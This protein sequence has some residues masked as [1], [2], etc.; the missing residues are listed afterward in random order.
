MKRLSCLLLDAN[1]VIHLFKLKIW[2]RLVDQC[3]VHL[4]RTVMGES[5]FYEDDRGQRV[6]F[7]LGTYEQAGTITVFEVSLT[8]IRVFRDRF[9]P[10][11]L[12]LPGPCRS[13]SPKRS[14]T[15]GRPRVWRRAFTELALGHPGRP[16]AAVYHSTVGPVLRHVRRSL[17]YSVD[18]EPAEPRVSSAREA[19]RNRGRIRVPP[20]MPGEWP[21]HLA[22]GRQPRPTAPRNPP[23]CFRSLPFAATASNNGCRV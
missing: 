23:E 15:G 1:V 17:R 7:D 8:D 6:D 16:N 5:H 18:G 2:D 13:S 14:G 4:A 12:D 11:Y 19:P 20:P 10:T 22:N 21:A 3:D 9:D